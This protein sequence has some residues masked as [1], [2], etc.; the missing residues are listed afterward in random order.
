[1]PF[2]AVRPHIVTS[3]NHVFV[4]GGNAGKMEFTRT[5]M[6]YDVLAN[7]WSSLPITA[8]YTF[9]MVAIK[10]VLTIIGGSNVVTA[11]VSNTL[12]S[13]EEG[14]G[15]WGVKFPA[16]PSKRC[17]TSAVST[18]GHVVVVGGISDSDSAYLDVVE[19]LDLSCMAWSTVCPFPIPVTF[20]SITVCSVTGSIFLLGGYVGGYMVLVEGYMVLL[21]RDTCMI[22]DT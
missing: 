14:T 12:T 18:P 16:M 10:G 17:A 19:T 15:K 7:K 21:R 2:G 22:L 6:K 13:Y 20:M 11:C 1:M 4:G 3:G 8:Y 5:V 9:S